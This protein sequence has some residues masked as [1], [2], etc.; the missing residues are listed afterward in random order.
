MQELG[1][2]LYAQVTGSYDWK[3]PHC[4][5]QNRHRIN[6]LKFTFKCRNPRCEYTH[7][8]GIAHWQTLPGRK[9][10]PPDQMVF[11]AG[12]WRSGCRTNV[13]LCECC[14]KAIVDS[15][16]TREESTRE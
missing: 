12:V 7:V 4:K 10:P 6:P 9:T 15:M 1:D 16:N 13:V 5:H 3:C 8:V 2:M 11:E 14:G